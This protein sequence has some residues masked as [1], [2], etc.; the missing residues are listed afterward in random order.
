METDGA[1]GGEKAESAASAETLVA[2]DTEN[3]PEVLLGSESWHS[4]LP[5][6]SS[7]CT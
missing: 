4:A 3:L 7:S 6:V 1:C 5:S 2:M